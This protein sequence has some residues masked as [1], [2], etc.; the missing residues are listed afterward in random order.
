MTYLIV[1]QFCSVLLLHYAGIFA[2]T[3][4]SVPTLLR[5]SSIDLNEERIINDIFQWLKLALHLAGEEEQRSKA[6]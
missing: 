1:N 3:V 6:L 2:F 4:D 5:V